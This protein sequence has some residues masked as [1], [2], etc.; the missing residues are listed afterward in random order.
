MTLLSTDSTLRIGIG[1]L[2]R[3]RRELAEAINELQAAVEGG[4]DRSVSGPLLEKLACATEAHFVAEEAM[5]TASK[6]PG[7]MLHAMKHKRLIEQ[8]SAFRA[9][10]RR[11]IPAM[12]RHSLNFLHDWVNIH[13][14][15][16][17]LN[18]GLWLNEHGKR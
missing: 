8:L 5:M 3:E 13:L 10:Y 11:N 2:D 17:D 1:E 4:K 12:D 18:F 16:D 7:L 9:R 6:C 14:Q 15:I